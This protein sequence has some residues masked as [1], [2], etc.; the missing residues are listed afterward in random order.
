MEIELLT[1]IAGIFLLSS[2]KFFF[3]PGTA[4][5]SG[6]TPYQT[7]LIT[8]SGGIFGISFFYFLGRWLILYIRKT[9]GSKDTVRTKKVFTRRNRSIVK[10]KEGFGLI[11][12]IIV[13]PAILSIPI[14]CVVAAKFYYNNK[15][16]YPL[17][18]VSTFAWSVGLTYFSE[19]IRQLFNGI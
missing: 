5:A 10:F 12:L 3:A 9:V 13:T 1:K 4:I 18:V 8:S 2:V 17:L 11:G 7:V 14:G 6:F 15:L 16:T 19:T